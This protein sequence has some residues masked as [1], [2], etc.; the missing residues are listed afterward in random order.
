VLGRLAVRLDNLLEVG[1]EGREVAVRP[2]LCPDLVADRAELGLAAH[3]LGRDP[4]VIVIDSRTCA[5]ITRSTLSLG[6]ATTSASALSRRWRVASETRSRAP[7]PAASQAA[8]PASPPTGR[9][10]VRASQFRMDLAFSRSL[11]LPHPF[12]ESG[13]T[14]S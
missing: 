12:Q 11:T 9:H 4:Q 3:Q 2:G 14:H 1:R 8:S 5:Q 13:I 6:S 7:R 10:L